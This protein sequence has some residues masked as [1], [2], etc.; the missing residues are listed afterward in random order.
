MSAVDIEEITERAFA[1]Y[2]ECLHWTGIAVSET[3]ELSEDSLDSVMSLDDWI[4]ALPPEQLDDA[5]ADVEAIIALAVEES[6]LPVY[7]VGSSPEQFGHDFALTRNRHGAGFWCSTD[8]VGDR[9]TELTRG[10]GE[11][12]AVAYVGLDDELVAGIE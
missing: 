12:T 4:E 7:L 3:G 10:Y 2:L 8:P 5:R 9:L 1:A 11:S 6:L